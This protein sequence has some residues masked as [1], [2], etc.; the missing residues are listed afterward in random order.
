MV[1]SLLL[2]AGRTP[3]ADAAVRKC[4]GKRVTIVGTHGPDHLR[5]TR[6]A[7]VIAGL[8]GNDVISGLGGRD[9]ICG[10]LGVDDLRGNG[11]ADRIYGGLDGVSADEELRD[12]DRLRGGP[13]ND[14]LVPGV[15]PHTI[16]DG[17]YD[18]L[19]YDTSPRRVVVNLAR[20]RA[21]GDGSDR[22]VINGPISVTTTRFADRV[23]GSRFKDLVFAQEGADYMPL[24]NDAWLHGRSHAQPLNR[25]AVRAAH[26]RP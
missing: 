15:D 9:T 22:L 17:A 11:G 3:T 7:D 6:R 12:G 24:A 25:Y 13:G 18:H 2:V 26:L 20:G 21:T 5:G 19:L 14:K 8:A 10:D 16:A 4:A 23:I 1:M